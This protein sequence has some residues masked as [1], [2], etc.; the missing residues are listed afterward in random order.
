[1]CRF[2]Q[3]LIAAG[4]YQ[5]SRGSPKS[6]ETAR[7]TCDVEP[8]PPG[9][10]SGEQ[11]A[12]NLA[13]V[14][15]LHC[16]V[17]SGVDDGPTTLTESIALCRAAGRDGTRTLVATPHINWDYP[18]VTPAVIHEKVAEL[19][20]ALR[21][22]A[23]ELTVRT[24]AEVALSRAG[25]LSDRDLRLLCLGGGPYLLL[26]L[27]WTSAGA[28]A[29]NA[30]R[31]LAHRGFRIVV[32][33]PERS[34]MLQRDAGVVQEL[35]NSGVLYCLDAG[36]LSRHAERRTRSAAWKLLAA[37]LA[38]VVASDCHD[39]IRRPP[40]LGSALARAGLTVAEIDHL[41]HAAPEAILNGEP[42]APALAVHRR[43][44]GKWRGAARRVSP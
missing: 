3:R 43:R 37:G 35:V 27:P 44:R 34:P 36:S 20:G 10:R 21:G 42:P 26:E 30:M 4:P 19:N 39:P 24:G 11:R 32:A 33:H 40:E 41:A 22:E 15:D 2:S 31:A 13:V 38:H 25:E 6:E 1:M 29:L 9:C 8:A 17:L 14:I 16:H 23:L 7:A 12:R 5:G 18:Q 28:G